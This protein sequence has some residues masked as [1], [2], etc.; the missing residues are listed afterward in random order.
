MAAML[1][2]TW[3]DDT[4]TEV[5]VVSEESILRY[6]HIANLIRDGIVLHPEWSS[7]ISTCAPNFVSEY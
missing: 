6:V 1:F 3:N 4:G 7:V 2:I 5:I